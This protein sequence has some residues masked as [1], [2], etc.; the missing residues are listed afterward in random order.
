MLVNAFFVLHLFAG[1][2]IIDVFQRTVLFGSED[3]AW[4]QWDSLQDGRFVPK[5]RG[6][7]VS[8]IAILDDDTDTAKE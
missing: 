1:W 4:S 7:F 2:Y 3:L 6:F 5:S 8:C